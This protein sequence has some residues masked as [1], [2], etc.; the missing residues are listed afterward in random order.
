MHTSRHMKGFIHSQR[1]V[2]FIQAWHICWFLTYLVLVS[3]EC[4][5]EVFVIATLLYTFV[6]VNVY[7]FAAACLSVIVD[8]VNKE[9]LIMFI[10]NFAQSFNDK[11]I[12]GIKSLTYFISHRFFSLLV[13]VVARTCFHRRF[14]YRS[15]HIRMLFLGGTNFDM[16]DPPRKEF[17]CLSE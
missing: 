16:S 8:V 15:G 12:C 10:G 13:S 1:N 2:W 5:E 7:S 9:Y 14:E 4:C 3:S 17:C 6:T 11:P